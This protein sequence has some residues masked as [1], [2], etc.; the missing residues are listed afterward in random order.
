MIEMI[1]IILM[2]IVRNIINKSFFEINIQ[3]YIIF[4]NIEIYTHDKYPM[5]YYPPEAMNTV[6]NV[7]IDEGVDDDVLC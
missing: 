6:E 3:I 5:Q 7:I 4:L 1:I 2:M